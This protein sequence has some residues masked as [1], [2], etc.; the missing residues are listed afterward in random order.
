MTGA[1]VVLVVG[2]HGLYRPFSLPA[3]HSAAAASWDIVSLV[4]GM[5][6]GSEPPR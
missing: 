1:V 6:A 2:K 3:A 5:V 4:T